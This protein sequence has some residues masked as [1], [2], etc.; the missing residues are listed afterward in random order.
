MTQDIAEF[1]KKS[2]DTKTFPC[3]TIGEMYGVGGIKFRG[4][5]KKSISNFSHWEQKGHAEIFILYPENIS[6]QFSLDEAAL[7]DDE[8]YIVLASKNQKAERYSHHCCKSNSE[9][10]HD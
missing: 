7:S 1:L 4:H 3:K 9:W 6:E 2:A 8:L 5:H 10:Y